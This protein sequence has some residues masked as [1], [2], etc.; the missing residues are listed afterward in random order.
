MS[1]SRLRNRRGAIKLAAFSLPFYGSPPALLSK[2]R[3]GFW[4]ERAGPAWL[5]AAPERCS[6]WAGRESRLHTEGGLEPAGARSS[7]HT[8]W[9]PKKQWGLTKHGRS[10]ERMTP[11]KD[12]LFWFP[13]KLSP[14]KKPTSS[15]R[16]CIIFF[17]SFD[18]FPS[19]H[20]LGL[21][22]HVGFPTLKSVSV[23]HKWILQG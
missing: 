7:K 9:S 20:G 5:T 1:H 3:M 12:D 11:W 15:L 6:H 22:T 21:N 2:P 14:G 18:F 10:H 17:A 8:A 13:H 4:S 23:H 19:T 16:I